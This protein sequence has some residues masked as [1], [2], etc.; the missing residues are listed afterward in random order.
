MYE[1]EHCGERFTVFQAMDDKHKAKCPQ[2][3]KRAQRVWNPAKFTIDFVPGY[4]Y[5]L[6]KYIDTKKQ[7]EEVMREVGARRIKD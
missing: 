4:D 5:G 6:G 7:R 3:G 2:C 1:F